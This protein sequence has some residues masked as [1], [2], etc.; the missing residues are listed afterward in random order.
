MTFKAL[1]PNIFYADI[2][3]GLT[4]F[5]SCLGFKVTYD[6]LNDAGHAFCVAERDSIKVHLVRDAVFAGK[7]RPELRLETDNIQALYTDV[8]QRHPSLLHPNVN[9]IVQRP[10]GVKEFTLLD[11]SGVCIVVQEWGQ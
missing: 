7:D 8:K 1:V 9:E 11:S 5:V 4:L 2:Q 10:W 6:Q 3:A